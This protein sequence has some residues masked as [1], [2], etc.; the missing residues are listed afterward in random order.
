LIGIALVAK[1]GPAGVK[2]S[3]A[4]RL[5]ARG[6]NFG[7]LYLMLPLLQVLQQPG[8]RYSSP[9]R[10]IGALAARSPFPP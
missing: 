1:I 6:I 5:N 8:K 9:S 10:T 2:F 7:G 3:M 4:Q